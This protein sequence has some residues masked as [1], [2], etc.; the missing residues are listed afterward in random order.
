VC[1]ASA[2][3]FGFSGR[4]GQDKRFVEWVKLITQ[5]RFS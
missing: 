5:F 4:G 1:I 3:V 2:A